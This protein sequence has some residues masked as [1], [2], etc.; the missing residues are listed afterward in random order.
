LRA[1]DG[2]A[3]TVKWLLAT[4]PHTTEDRAWQLLAFHWSG[5]S[6]SAIGPAAR[7]LTAEQRADG[8]WSQLATLD[9]DAYA[10]GQ[11][12]VALANVG[13][14]TP[15]DPAYQRGVRF[16]LNTQF[17]DG[18]WRVP[19]RSLPIQPLFDIGFPHGADSWISAAGTNWATMAL[20][21]AVVHQ[22]K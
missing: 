15:G 22:T 3:R 2:A 11:A 16:L 19:T 4:T 20:A 14:L 10:T 18:S 9:S 17:A 5:R 8:G 6:R 21:R 7:A 12:L 1:H 13:A